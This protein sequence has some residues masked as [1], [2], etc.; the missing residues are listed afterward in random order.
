MIYPIIP[1]ITTTIANEKGID[2]L[3]AK[4][5]KANKGK[6]DLKLIKKIMDFNSE[7]WKKKKDEGVSLRDSIEGI[8][9]PKELKDFELDLKECHGLI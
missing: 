9:I 1:Q 3:K 8:K 5:P 2:L 7:V 4:Y 6:S